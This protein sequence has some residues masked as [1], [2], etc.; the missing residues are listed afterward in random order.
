[1]R[2]ADTR[3]REGKGGEGKEKGRRREGKGKGKEKGLTFGVHGGRSK[4]I[5]FTALISPF[6][7]SE[8]GKGKGVREKGGRGQS[9]KA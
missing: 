9:H 2:N 6:C 7:S 5:P 3:G 8:R 1:M 4:L